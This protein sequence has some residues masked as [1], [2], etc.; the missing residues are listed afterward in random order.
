MADQTPNIG[1]DLAAAA[2]AA[3]EVR[4]DLEASYGGPLHPSVAQLVDV[5]SR[6]AF[7]KGAAYQLA[8]DTQAIR[9]ATR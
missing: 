4:M 7:M 8:E 9:R 6:I 2:E 5:A 3:A 1:P